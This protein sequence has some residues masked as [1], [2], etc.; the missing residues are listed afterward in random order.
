MH[1]HS[2]ESHGSSPMGRTVVRAGKLFDGVGRTLTDDAVVVVAGAQVAAAAPA[3]DVEVH[4]DDLVID[5]RPCT[6][7]PGLIDAHVHLMGQNPA[8]AH[9][10]PIEYRAVRSA[11]QAKALLEAGFTTLR[12]LGSQTSVALKQAIDD[13]AVP[14][15]RMIAAG[16]AIARTGGPWFGM[17]PSWRWVRPADGVDACR[18]AVHRAAFGKDPASSRSEPPPGAATRRGARFRPTPWPRC[19]A[20]VEEAH[21]WGLRVAAHAMGDEG[22]RR[23]V[24]GGVDTVEHGYNITDDTLG[25]IIERGVYLV[26]TL[27]ARAFSTSDDGRQTYDG[28]GALVAERLCR[29]SAP[30]SRNRHHG[31]RRGCRTA[32]R[33]RSSSGL[34]PRPWNPSTRCCRARAWRRRRLGSIRTWAACNLE[35][36]ADL[37]AVRENPLRDLDAPATGR[38]RHAGRPGSRGALTHAPLVRASV[39]S[40]GFAPDGV[41]DGVV[42]F[43]AQL[44]KRRAAPVEVFRDVACH[45]MTVTEIAQGRLLVEA[46]ILGDGAACVEATSLGRVG[47]TRQFAGND[48]SFPLFGRI[49]NGNSVP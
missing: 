14:G 5:L 39:L 31:R 17:E 10:G 47:G 6:V 22:V 25:L 28:S 26:P 29:R 24:L 3:S 19:R 45:E 49:G 38:I 9:P 48:Q 11:G 33:M 30:G 37:V 40:R 35:R 36:T 8:H 1:A 42:H 12:D 4:P 23:A 20:V 43:A 34:W 2:H 32:T 15:P 16:Y 18:Q 44:R 46:H 7:L 21:A 13:G 27:R 41:G